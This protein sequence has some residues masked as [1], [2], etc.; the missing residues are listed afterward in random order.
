MFSI[1]GEVFVILIF[2]IFILMEVDRISARVIWAYGEENAP[3]ILAVADDI[4]ASVMKYLWVKT[5]INIATGLLTSLVLGVGGIDF[6]IL[7]GIIAFVLNYIPYLGSVFAVAFPVLMALIQI[8]PLGALVILLCLLVVHFALGN[9]HRAKGD[10]PGA[11]PLPAGGADRPG[12]LGVALGVRG[13]GAGD[14]DHGHHQDRHGAYT[15]HPQ[16]RALYERRTGAA[17]RR[18]PRPEAYPDLFAV[19]QGQQGMRRPA[20]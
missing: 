14:P 11:E 20:A 8:T 5:L 9:F 15:G 2:M 7:W 3:E 16:P 6:Y 13:D 19:A 1:V 12:L 18:A 17:A 10:R 4:N